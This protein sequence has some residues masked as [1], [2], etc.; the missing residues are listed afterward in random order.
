[1]FE[2]EE[3]V[4]CAN[5]TPGLKSITISKWKLNNKHTQRTQEFMWFGKLP[6]STETMEKFHYKNKEI[7]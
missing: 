7:Q 5:G 4:C 2:N 1:M 6:I 3:D